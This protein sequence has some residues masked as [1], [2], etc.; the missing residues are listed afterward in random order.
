VVDEDTGEPITDRTLHQRRGHRGIDT[1]G[2]AADR[3]TRRTDLFLDG[4][5]QRVGDVRGGP[6]R[7]DSGGLVQESAQDLL[8]VW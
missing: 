1:T 8:S 2:Q 3:L 4:V 5:D 6:V 7:L